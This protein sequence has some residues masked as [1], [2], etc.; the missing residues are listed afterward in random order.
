MN[1]SFDFNALC[2]FLQQGQRAIW[3]LCGEEDECRAI[4]KWYCRHLPALLWR[5][6]QPS[7]RP[8]AIIGAEY[9]LLL[10][11]S[12]HDFDPNQF[13]AAVGALQGGGVLI[14]LLPPTRCWPQGWPDR[15]QQRL[16]VYPWQ[17]EALDRRYQQRLVRFLSVAK[18]PLFV[19]EVAAARGGGWQNLALLQQLRQ[20]PLGL[21]LTRAEQIR[22][23]AYLERNATGHRYRPVVI[24][25]DRGR[26]K[27]TLLGLAAAALLKRKLGH[28]VVVALQRSMVTTLFE[29]ARRQLPGAR[30]D[31]NG[32]TWRGRQLRYCCATDADVSG[33]D[34]VVVDE[35]AT[36]PLERLQQWLISLPRLVLATTVDGYEGSGRGFQLRLLPW[37]KRE[38][39]NWQLCQL[40]QP[41]RWLSDDKLEPWSRQL[42]LLESQ[43]S[44]ESVWVPDLDRVVLREFNREALWQQE[45]LLQQLF[46]LLVAAHYQ[47]TPLDLRHLLDGPNIRLFGLW[48]P[49]STLLAVAMVAMEGE[50]PPALSEAVRF[51]VRRPR[52]HL[53]VQTLINHVGLAS[54][55]GLRWA[56][57]V[58]VAVEPSLQ[59]RGLGRK[60]ITTLQQ[61][62][63]RQGIDMI[64]ALFAADSALIDFWHSLSWRC[65]YCALKINRSSGRRSLVM[66][67]GLSEAGR[68]AEHHFLSRYAPQWWQLL[69]GA[70]QRL[71]SELVWRI[72]ADLPL[73]QRL[74]RE[75]YDDLEAFAYGRREPETV[76]LPLKVMLQSKL[77]YAASSLPPWSDR[78]WLV[79]LLFQRAAPEEIG[80]LSGG[81][82]Q[83]VERLR[84]YCRQWLQSDL[85]D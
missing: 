18:P 13:A 32:L 58:R 55:G 24:L 22:A 34:W 28:I 5:S 79:A 3:L 62:L 73:P 53:L 15:V 60:L 78:A 35:A 75:D 26:G 6:L 46:E 56:R 40:Q 65:G 10:L 74:E 36:L 14:W 69:L 37:L 47:T 59:R 51:N 20:P 30:L 33:A 72:G 4:A 49:E 23:L 80:R 61:Q 50:L 27:S 66:L 64:G 29:Q 21:N 76:L 38:L 11:S 52:G 82:R 17:A 43:P 85:F 41:Q 8:E 9:R 42:L 16:A 7:D 77:W 84:A 48:T 1:A 81:R 44:A 63:Q 19:A 83:W 39:P 25:A 54:S 57:I 71:E 70:L 67:H 45:P 12:H 68:A 31:R 2:R